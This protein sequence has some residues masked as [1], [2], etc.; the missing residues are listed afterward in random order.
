MMKINDFFQKHF[1]DHKK[2]GHEY[3]VDCPY[4][5]RKDKMSVNDEKQLFQCWA[6]SCRETG[7]ISKLYALKGEQ[8]AE[9]PLAK[10]ELAD[11]MR[12]MTKTVADFLQTRG[13]SISTINKNIFDVM[14]T[15]NNEVAFVYRKKFDIHGIK[16]RD[17]KQK[18]FGG[19]KLKPLTL[20]KLDF[21]DV[22]KPLIICE[23]EID[24]LSFEEQGI[25]NVVSVPAGV[26]ALE[27]IDTDF[28]ELAKF[29][30]IILALDSDEAGKKAV[31]KIAK[32]LPE[33][34]EIEILDYSEYKD[35]N[36]ILM[37]GKSLQDYIDCAKSFDSNYY[38]EMQA[39]DIHAEMEKYDIGSLEWNR[40][41]GA[42]R[43]GELTLWTGKAG[44]GK[45]TI[46]NQVMLTILHQGINA[47]VYSPELTD[48]QYKTWTCRQLIG[49]SENNFFTT[50]DKI[51]QEKAFHVKKEI[52]DKMSVWL[53]KK[54]SYLSSKNIMTDREIIKQVVR[55]IKK[56]NTRFIVID[57]LMKIIFDNK[58]EAELYSRQTEFVRELSGIAKEYNVS[59][60]LVAHP[61]KHAQSEPDQYDVSGSSNVTNLVDNIYY[62]RRITDN[63]LETD[64]KKHAALISSY[65]ASTA[66]MVLKSREGEKVGRWHFYQFD[67]TRKTVNYYCER[68]KYIPWGEDDDDDGLA[69]PF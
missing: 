38:A 17:I 47:L 58:T 69:F 40:A 6:G 27:W 12:R 30:T 59:I 65:A 24:Q 43:M 20:W 1:P 53:D 36:E 51:L 66:M 49:E 28:E 23:G 31:E 42:L 63:C 37:A 44:S 7:H 46:L 35:A 56:K 11:Y 14:S 62:W 26:A 10:H 52:T 13:I 34:V 33:E 32:R 16:T 61:K 5:G 48:K 19:K 15:A 3:I 9:R 60:N 4:C 39:I 8:Y 57:N 67:I 64:F 21:C 18:K 41:V 22:E 2:K 54:L 29:K 25:L 68:K 55:N 45:S 50:Y